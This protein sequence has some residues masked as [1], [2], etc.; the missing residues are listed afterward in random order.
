MMTNC[1]KMSSAFL[2]LMHRFYSSRFI[3]KAAER[4]FA[5]AS[6]YSPPEC[7]L[8]AETITNSSRNATFEL[9]LAEDYDQLDGPVLATS[10]GALK[11]R[12]AHRCW[13]KHSTFLEHL[14]GVHNVLRLW[15]QGQKIARVGLFHSAYSNSY[16]NLAL[17]DPWTERDVMTRL[18]GPEAEE[19][20]HLFCIIDRQKVVV[21]TVL[22]QGFIPL[23]GLSVPHLREADKEVFLSAET[24]RLLV[25]FTMAD[26]ADQYFGWQD[27]LFGGGGEAGSM[28]IPGQDRE[29]RHDTAALWPGVSK[30][31]LWMSY[32]SDLAQVVKRFHDE[33]GSARDEALPA[34]PP[35]FANGTSTLL[36]QDEEKARDLYWS[37]VSSSGEPD[38]DP[39][40]TIQQ[41]Q[42]CHERNPWAFE[43]LVLLAQKLL[44]QNDHERAQAAAT[45]ALQLQQ[46]WGTAWDKRLSFGAWVA[47]T[48]VLLQRASERDPWPTNSWEVNNLGLVY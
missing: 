23:E 34:I 1:M 5:T 45:Q 39:K 44:H 3:V 8:S 6:V 22:K 9:I 26:I 40:N 33:M 13:H 28:I 17:F 24:L 16:V 35:V 29:D 18:I 20:V 7:F 27:Q 15:G 4:T 36:L 14:V 19:L 48:R 42:E 43:P 2:L 21:N 47:W 32:V 30:P 46:D 38:N 25:V 41:L 31:G 11:Q 37:V 12:G 10:I